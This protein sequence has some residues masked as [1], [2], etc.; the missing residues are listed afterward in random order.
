MSPPTLAGARPS[1]YR[2]LQRCGTGWRE[3]WWMDGRLGAPRGPALAGARWRARLAALAPLI[4]LGA[5]S[6]FGRSPPLVCPRTAIIDQLSS[7]D[8]YREGAPAG[9]ENLAYRVALENI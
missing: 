7:A 4:L 5:C 1:G 3:D 2:S 8:R 9:A 6:L